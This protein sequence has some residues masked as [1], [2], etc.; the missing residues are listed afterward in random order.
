MALVC[1]ICTNKKR[2]QIEAAIAAGESLRHIASQWNVGYKAVDRHKKNCIPPILQEVQATQKRE[3]AITVMGDLDWLRS[4]AQALYAEMREQVSD[5]RPVVQLLGEMRQQA[6][7]RAELTGELDQRTQ[8]NIQQTPDWQE[9]RSAFLQAL[10][11]LPEA[12]ARVLRVME[13]RSA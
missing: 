3:T 5:Y 13:V 11:D 7:L 4:E 9:M 10:S 1:S 12:K 2:A 8:I 6:K